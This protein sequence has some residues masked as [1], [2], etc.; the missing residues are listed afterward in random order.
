M[1]RVLVQ[2]LG[3]GVVALAGR[4]SLPDGRV[5]PRAVTRVAAIS[6]TGIVSVEQFVGVAL[7]AMVDVF[8]PIANPSGFVDL[9]MLDSRLLDGYDTS[10]TGLERKNT[11]V[12]DR[13]TTVRGA[14]AG[15]RRTRGAVG[16]TVP[17]RAGLAIA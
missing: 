8:E 15:R 11:H 2:T 6:A 17:R 1:S 16:P 12:G 10:G 4:R 13:T 9:A 3:G 5:L 7:E 14:D